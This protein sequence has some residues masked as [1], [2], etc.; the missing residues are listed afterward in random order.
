VSGNPPHLGTFWAELAGAAERRRQERPGGVSVVE[1][2]PRQAQPLLV[3]ARHLIDELERV[4]DECAEQCQVSVVAIGTGQRRRCRL[5]DD[6]REQGG[7]RNGASAAFM[8][9]GDQLG[10]A[11]SLG[12]AGHFDGSSRR[13]R[14]EIRPRP[15]TFGRK[16]VD[17]DRTRLGGPGVTVREPVGADGPEAES[18]PLQA[19][20]D[21][22]QGTTHSANV[23]DHVAVLT[24][25]RRELSVL[26]RMQQHHLAADES[27]RHL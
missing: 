13:G 4:R 22:R 11:Q 1:K 10:P 23:R 12:A 26:D 9:D 27:P 14:R 20:H 17:D 19:G 6:R 5:A 25:L 21:V 7:P 18:H 24:D 2:P 15:E 16:D 3:L 8:H